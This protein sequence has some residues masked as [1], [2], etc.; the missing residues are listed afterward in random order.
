[1]YLLDKN[2]RDEAFSMSFLDA[3]NP[4]FWK[5]ITDIEIKDDLNI[6]DDSYEAFRKKNA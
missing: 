1:M 2:I 3:F 6:Y 5:N 4:E